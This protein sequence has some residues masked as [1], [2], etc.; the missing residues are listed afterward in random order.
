MRKGMGLK[1]LKTCK[2]LKNFVKICQ[3]HKKKVPVFPILRSKVQILCRCSKI[4]RRRASARLQLLEALHCTAS[5]KVPP[6]G[7]LFHIRSGPLHL[8]TYSNCC[9]VCSIH[10]EHSIFICS[11]RSKQNGLHFIDDLTMLLFHYLVLTILS[12]NCS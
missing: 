12:L 6:S 4:L 3:N 9:Q 11:E 1:C 10:M 8:R 2:T 7:R 5:Y